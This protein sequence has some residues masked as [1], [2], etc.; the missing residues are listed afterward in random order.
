M[1]FTAHKKLAMGEKGPATELKLGTYA[2]SGVSA[3][4]ATDTGCDPLSPIALIT[5]TTVTET[6]YSAQ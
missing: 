3:M 6:I 5:T 4:P 2:H 1:H